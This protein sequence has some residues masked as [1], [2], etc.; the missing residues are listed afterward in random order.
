MQEGDTLDITC[1][2]CDHRIFFHYNDVPDINPKPKTNVDRIY[3][4]VGRLEF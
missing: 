4:P 1:R 3:R 2:R